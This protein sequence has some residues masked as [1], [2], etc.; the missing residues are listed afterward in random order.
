MTRTK[1]L[2]ELTSLLSLLRTHQRAC[3]SS[4]ANI[5]ETETH[6]DLPTQI[7]TFLLLRKEL[8]MHSF[9]KE[10]FYLLKRLPTRDLESTSDFTSAML[11][12]M[13]ITLRLRTLALAQSGL[14][15]MRK[16]ETMEQR[17]HS[18][19]LFIHSQWTKQ[20]ESILWFLLS[21][22]M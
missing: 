19:I 9:Q 13:P 3:H 12:R 21:S 22:Y 5:T 18:G 17:L 10:S 6:G 16:M 14:S 15:R 2:R 8:M 1:L 4:S 20:K 7:S 11:T